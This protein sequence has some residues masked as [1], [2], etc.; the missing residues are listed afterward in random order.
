MRPELC[1]RVFAVAVSLAVAG[2]ASSDVISIDVPLT[3]GASLDTS[4]DGWNGAG[5]PGVLPVA[6][7]DWWY[8]IDGFGNS[9]V[10]IREDWI[11]GGPVEFVVEVT[12]DFG[13][14]GP[15]NDPETL[16]TINKELT[17]NTGVVWESFLVQLLDPIPAGLI[18]VLPGGTSDVFL[19]A[20]VLEPNPGDPV[21]IFFD[22]GTVNPGESVQL[23]YSFMV[24]EGAGVVSYKTV[25]IPNMIPGPATFALLGLGGVG[26]ARRRR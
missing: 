1:Q 26:V 8:V 4:P 13:E 6:G 10:S 22:G 11:G 16:V 21:F 25:Q 3:D 24:P 17:N 7:D 20:Q 12:T 2:S 14:P 15:R 5:G 19:N 18:E 9:T 23:G